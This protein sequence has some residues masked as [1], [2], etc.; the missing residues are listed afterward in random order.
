MENQKESDDVTQTIDT[1]ITIRSLIIGCLIGSVLAASNIYIGLKSGWSTSTNIFSALFGF[2]VLSAV[3][4]TTNKILSTN[5]DFGIKENCILQTTATAA[6]SLTGGFVMAVPALI[7]FGNTYSFTDLF[8]WALC[9]AYF[10]MFFGI[11]LRNYAIIIK[12]LPFPSGLATALTLKEL[13]R[14]RENNRIRKQLGPEEQAV[15]VKN[16]LTAANMLIM[17]FIVS[18]IVVLIGSYIPVLYIQPIFYWMALLVSG[19]AH[20]IHSIPFEDLWF[21]QSIFWQ[22]SEWHW[23]VNI[24]PAFIGIGM[25]MGFKSAIS[26]FIGSLTAFAVVGPLLLYFDVLGA[27]WGYS[28]PINAP[29]VQYWML[30][31]GI[32]FMTVSSF[33]HLLLTLNYRSLFLFVLHWIK[34]MFNKKQP[35]P[36]SEIEMDQFSDEEQFETVNGE[37][38]EPI[39]EMDANEIHEKDLPVNIEQEIELEGELN[40][41]VS[42]K[43]REEDQQIETEK[44]GGG[45]S[46][47]H[48]IWIGG[49]TASTVFTVFVLSVFFDVIWYEVV[50]ALVLSFI[51]SLVAVQVSGETD[52]N[53]IGAVSHVTQLFFALI[54]PHQPTKNIIAGNVCAASAGQSVD[55]LTDL[56]TGYELSVSPRAQFIAQTVG[57]LAGVFSAVCTFEILTTAYPCIMSLETLEHCP[58][59]VPA[60]TTWYGFTY[61]L[62]ADWTSVATLFPPYCFTAVVIATIISIVLPVLE[63]FV[64]PNSYKKLM[65]SLTAYGLAFIT[66]PYISL[67]M[68]IGAVVLVVWS[69]FS[70]RTKEKFGYSVA[71][72]ISAGEGVAGVLV[73]ILMILGVEF[74]WCI[75]MP[76]VGAFSCS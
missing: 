1:E 66:A 57:S 74:K 20:W 68:F 2:V 47:P 41:R 27:A 45:K 49:L 52:I 46:I 21:T 60:G 55:M 53:P 69:K 7:W 72:G 24:S 25:L 54:A 36:F 58:F 32:V 56:K 29:S 71:A 65:P 15:V 8:L 9:A 59:S 42:S 34:N 51:M 31:P 11:P 40:E 17:C 16:T 19:L 70:L 37:R 67:A 63:I 38:N 4:K 28:D 43:E 48:W 39:N 23:A 35:K 14:S 75:G 18:F 26:Y 13:F 44:K 22:I 6:G 12:Q 10:G 61:A 62:T 76:S 73:A 64:L 33:T 50:F 5:F 3:T 30:W